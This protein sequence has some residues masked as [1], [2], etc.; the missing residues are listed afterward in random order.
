MMQPGHVLAGGAQHHAKS[1]FL[2]P[3]PVQMNAVANDSCDI[4][5]E[6]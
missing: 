6:P 5:R 2:R 3:F 1:N 4:G